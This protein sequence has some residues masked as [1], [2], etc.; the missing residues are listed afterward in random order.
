M[1]EFA[2]TVSA[3]KRRPPEQLSG[4][5]FK[6]YTQPLIVDGKKRDLSGFVYL[7]DDKSTPTA[8]QPI[9]LDERLVLPQTIGYVVKH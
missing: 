9:Y 8:G 6:K 1:N 7:S 4:G 5:E 3:D 2:K